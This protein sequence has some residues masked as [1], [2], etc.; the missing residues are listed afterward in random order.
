MSQKLSPPVPHLRSAQV[1]KSHTDA[2]QKSIGNSNNNEEDDNV[3]NTFS[4][5]KTRF[6]QLSLQQTKL[7]SSSSSPVG[8]GET[9]KKKTNNNIRQSAFASATAKT[10]DSDSNPFEDTH[11]LDPFADEN[12]MVAVNNSDSSKEF[13]PF[14]SNI[15]HEEPEVLHFDK[16][17]YAAAPKNEL[18]SKPKP[19]AKPKNTISFSISPP[20]PTRTNQQPFR[21]PFDDTDKSVEGHDSSENPRH[22]FS[23]SNPPKKPI[24][25][26][27]LRNDT[28]HEQNTTQ[29]VKPAL[30]PRRP[31]KIPEQSEKSEVKKAATPSPPR[32]PPLPNVKPSANH[33]P[34]LPDRPALPPKSM[35][36]D[37]S[38]LKR[39]PSKLTV[40]K[41][42]PTQDNSGSESSIG[43]I[44]S[45]D[46]RS[47]Y[48]STLDQTQMA[49]GFPDSLHA[50]RRAPHFEG[51]KKE[52]HHKGTIRAF[53]IAGDY[54]VTALSSTRVW[55]LQTAENTA[56]ISHGDSKVTCLVLRPAR[57]LEDVGRFIWCGTQDGALIAIDINT[58]KIVE[59]ISK[60]HNH[61][62]SYILRYE[63]QLWTIDENGKLN[64]WSS[65]N[66][67]EAISLN[68]TPKPLRVAS[69]QTCALI[70]GHNLWMAAGKN[71]EIFN[72]VEEQKGS[73]IPPKRDVGHDVGN[74]TCMAQTSNTKVVYVGHDNGMMTVWDANTLNKLSV[75]SV[76][77]YCIT[78]LLGV[79]EY[80]WAGFKTGKIYVYDAR[81]IKG[82]WVV[83]KEWQ[84]HKTTVT[85][86]LLDDEGFCRDKIGRMQV[87]SMSEE[88]YISVWDGLMQEDWFANK[89][90]EREK[91][92]CRY[93]DIKVLI[94]SWNIDASKPADL[95][96]KS[97]EDVKFLSLWFTS[98]DSPDLIVVG[99]QE[100]IDLESKKMTAK[101]M[102]M[103]KKKADKAL[104]EN[105]TQRYRLWHEKLVKAVREHAGFSNNCNYKLVRSENLVGLFTD[106]FIKE[107]EWDRLKNIDVT[108][109]KTGLGGYHG[110]KG[111]IATRFIYDDSSICFVN[112]HLAAGQAHT[113]QRNTDT[114]KILDS[115]EF[116]PL[117]S[118]NEWN[119]YSQVF[120]D[121]G[122]GSN[123]LDHEICF[124]SGD[125]N[126]RIDLPR[127]LVIAK[128]RDED[129]S[130][131]RE[132]D[133]LIKQRLKNP[134][135]R[136]K[137][138]TE[139]ELNFAPTYKYNPGEDTYDTSE[140]QRTPAWC[141]RILWRGN[142]IK[143]L[144]YQR[145]ECKV[146][147]HRPI[148]GGFI[149]TTKSIDQGAKVEVEEEVKA[150]WQERFD[151]EKRKRKFLWL[152]KC[153]WDPDLSN[154]VMRET[155]YNLRKAIEILNRSSEIN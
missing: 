66:E 83:L 130:I 10:V 5:L 33:R 15:I 113:S 32:K 1:D 22:A 154:K 9:L 148:S 116:P 57:R 82:P 143:Q 78:S 92:Y 91:E 38:E 134:G 46:E 42:K 26:A 96:K 124:F 6:E 14:S 75:V 107:S 29:E 70:V 60:A 28:M 64:K 100:I 24:R 89:M 18:S 101:T 112:C 56:T 65:D 63:S 110:N 135:F 62:I 61:A 121:G 122:D 132:N 133:Q 79:G 127:D 76:S 139:G 105:I 27:G 120:V 144:N 73:T 114:G 86:L 136:L 140:K 35:T 97:A 137:S 44:D 47:E 125:L 16:N 153:G 85:G 8:T 81:K 104:A 131:L 77:N 88:G 117:A 23:N 58:G 72:P 146:S 19:I 2:E 3:P 71:I 53:G 147:D 17:N 69:K 25:R 129:F 155:D 102:L 98:V 41:R 108:K 123:I 59:M 80:L 51:L 95:E 68:S 90:V 43:E 126:Y 119:E 48:N 118:H 151:E 13:S 11:A 34:P 152:I 30:P 94:C 50:N 52:I 138:F 67:H 45:S 149:V 36:I 40:P 21:S 99:F 74:I 111:A 109:C 4:S 115:V 37:E 103:P 55:K 93:R 31:T 39:R 141:D 49:S 54:A 84:A 87:G 20:L 7:P 12:D 150:E 142:K 128:I 145:Y 106:V